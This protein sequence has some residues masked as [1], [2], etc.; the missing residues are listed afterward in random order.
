MD[1]RRT[2]GNS[3]ESFVCEYLEK[4]GYTI[5]KRNYSTRGGEV[6][7]IAQYDSLICFIEVKTRAKYHVSIGEII[8]KT[9]QA[10]IIATAKHY[11]SQISAAYIARFD[12]AFV[13]TNDTTA[14]Q[15]TYIPNA[16]NEEC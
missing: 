5:L 15:V 4:Q 6:D 3:G 12:V 7:I 14:P 9:K 8:T 11:L 13:I 1:I 2:F 16:F 10:K